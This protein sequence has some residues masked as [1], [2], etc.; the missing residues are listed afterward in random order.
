MPSASSQQI[1]RPP[2]GPRAAQGHDWPR[3]YRAFFSLF[4]A[5]EYFEAHEVLEDLWAIEV[6]PLKNYYKGLIQA[7][8][9]ICHWERG[10]L[11]GARKLWLSA[12]GYLSVYPSRYEGFELEAFRSRLSQLFEPLL[13][14][15]GP[16][17]LDRMLI[18]V[19][20]LND[21]P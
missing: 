15:P 13:A 6:P 12:Q 9:A 5:G 3:E 21:E 8:V 16:A 17:H 1:L 2:D 18:P 7:A 20:E 10:N 11:S 19:L 4:N 14:Q